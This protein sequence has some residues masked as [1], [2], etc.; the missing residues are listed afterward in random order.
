MP[1][2]DA[3]LERPLREYIAVPDG[4]FNPW[5]LHPES[6]KAEGMC[7]VK[8]LHS[9]FLQRKRERATVDGRT[10]WR[11][12]YENARDV[13]HIEKSLDRIFNELYPRPNTYPWDEEG[14]GCNWRKEGCTSRMILRFCERNDLICHIFHVA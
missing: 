4:C 12:S 11:T 10:T 7:A 13:R 5:D 2:A 3:V 6:L 1:T 14:D 8:M 9:C